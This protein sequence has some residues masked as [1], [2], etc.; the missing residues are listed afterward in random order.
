MIVWMID[1]LLAY[2]LALERGEQGPVLTSDVELE[3]PRALV[4]QRAMRA[5]RR[6]VECW[7]S[8]D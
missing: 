3:R 2:S 7:A 8:L 4:R 1:C 5:Q 6:L